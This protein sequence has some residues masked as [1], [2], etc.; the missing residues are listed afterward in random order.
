MECAI[1]VASAPSIVSSLLV[2]SRLFLD[3]LML[4]VLLSLLLFVVLKEEE[5]SH[6]TSKT[7]SSVLFVPYPYAYVHLSNTLP[8]RTG[9]PLAKGCSV[10]APHFCPLR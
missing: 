4:L 8:Q 6:I 2:F 1:N 9:P 3:G 5:D 7:H 10:S